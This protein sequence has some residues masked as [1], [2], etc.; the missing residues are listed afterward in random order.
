MLERYTQQATAELLAKYGAF[1]AHGK[2]QFDTQREHGVI[3][4]R[5]GKELYCP[6]N[7]SAAFLEEWEQVHATAVAKVLEDHTREELILHELARHQCSYTGNITPA[8]L[9]LAVYGITKKEVLAVYKE[10][11]HA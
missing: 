7:K 6:K 11:R 9:A 2:Q 3:Y 4:V 5:L 8:V 1:I 10:D